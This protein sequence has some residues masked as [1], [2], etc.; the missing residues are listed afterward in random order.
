MLQIIIKKILLLLFIIIFIFILNI[1]INKN[2]TESFNNNK[3]IHIYI[4]GENNIA[5]NYDVPKAD[6]NILTYKTKNHYYIPYFLYSFKNYKNIENNWNNSIDKF[7]SRKYDIVYSSSNCNGGEGAV[8]RYE[9]FS[10]LKLINNKIISIGGC[11]TTPNMKTPKEEIRIPGKSFH[12]NDSKYKDYKLCIAIENSISD[13]YITEKI[14]NAYM[15][16]CIPIIWSG[17]NKTNKEYY[18]IFNKESFIDLSDFDNDEEFCMYI[19]NLL[20]NPEQL[21]KM[22]R[23]SIFKKPYFKRLNWYNDNSLN[24]IKDVIN[25]KCKKKNITLYK[26]K[27]S[28]NWSAD[29]ISK[30][31]EDNNV[32][33]KYFETDY[34]NNGADGSI[35]PDSKY[36]DSD[37]DIIVTEYAG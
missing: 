19:E 27:A 21:L 28:F 9:L 29:L 2:L 16:G 23:E 32:K 15:G 13:G 10:K 30:L 12:Q 5:H 20:N 35:L 11:Q 37:A 34:P 4:S 6:I 24:D 36:Y 17:T 8:R 18:N 7:L 25:K 1:N 26:N 22:R 14:I 3:P 31:L 33:I